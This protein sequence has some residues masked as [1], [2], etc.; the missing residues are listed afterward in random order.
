LIEESKVG[1]GDVLDLLGERAGAFEIAGGVGM[2]E[3]LSSGMAS[4][5]ERNWP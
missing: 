4:A 1:A 5:T 3:Y 2:K